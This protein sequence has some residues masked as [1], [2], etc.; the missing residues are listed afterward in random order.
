[1]MP[2]LAKR[3]IRVSS[4]LCGDL[5][6]VPG[7]E[8]QHDFD[9]EEWYEGQ[10]FPPG[11]V[12]ATGGDECRVTIDIP[13]L[14]RR[15]LDAY[16]RGDIGMATPFSFDLDFGFFVD[17]SKAQGPGSR[18][19]LQKLGGHVT[20]AEVPCR[21]DSYLSED[22]R[23]YRIIAGPCE[24]ALRFVQHQ[25]S[26]VR[27]DPDLQPAP[28]GCISAIVTMPENAADLPLHTIMIVAVGSQGEVGCRWH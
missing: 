1:M 2:D 25:D 6:T 13:D 26:P 5:A 23:K 18:F 20:V 28:A 11:V 7:G 3:Q 24:N 9:S 8:D 10:E 27:I 17:H 4:D 19:F 21:V 15:M 14:T 12:L 16:F 22:R